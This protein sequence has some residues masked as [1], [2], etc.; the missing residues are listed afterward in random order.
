[1]DDDA[2]KSM[3]CFM[4]EITEKDVSENPAA[5]ALSHLL[6]EDTP[7]CERVDRLKMS[8]NN[9]LSMGLKTGNAHLFT[10]AIEFYTQGLDVKCDDRR[11]N[12]Q[13]FSNRAQAHLYRQNYGM[14]LA[15][16]QRAI[17]LDPSHVK[18]YFRGAT[19]GLAL[20]DMNRASTL[21]KRG[22]ELPG[23]S[24]NVELLTL[25][26]EIN[27]R[28]EA[29]K[30]K[31][32]KELRAQ[33]EKLKMEMITRRVMKECGIQ[34]GPPEIVSEQWSLYCQD[35]FI[36]LREG[37]T[38][39]RRFPLLFLYDEYDQTDFVQSAD[40]KSTFLEQLSQMFPPMAS[41]P[42]WD[43]KGR[44][45]VSKL[46][47]FYRVVASG[48]YVRVSPAATIKQVLQ[49]DTYIL[50]GMLPTFHIVPTDSSYVSQFLSA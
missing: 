13:L 9:N 24:G 39:E 2:W 40:W 32:N 28:V 14:A 43:D 42:P 22:L 46:A 8:G 38:A 49:S 35:A 16:A 6:H 5:A 11:L 21:V 17:L 37:V 31:Y 50:P 23:E 26:A 30:V 15:D 41:A 27:R 20:N 25:S 29:A 19:A 47:V 48:K 45:E 10:S 18:S 36:K 44:Y 3:P 4:D 33:Q 1:M 34:S 12:M 7:P